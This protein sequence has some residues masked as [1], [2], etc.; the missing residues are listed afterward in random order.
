MRVSGKSYD[1]GRIRPPYNR[2]VPRTLALEQVEAKRTRGFQV[3][4]YFNMYEM[5]KV[6][7][8]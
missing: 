7:L 3:Y 6:V 8:L 4:M 2:R 5:F 1:V